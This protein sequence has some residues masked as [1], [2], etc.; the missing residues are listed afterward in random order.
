M[1]TANP[2]A[3]LNCPLLGCDPL[4]SCERGVKPIVDALERALGGRQQ[5]VQVGL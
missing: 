3:L 2:E 1:V 5:V 4:R